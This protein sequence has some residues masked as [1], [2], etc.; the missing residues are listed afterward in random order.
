MYNESMCKS[1]IFEIYKIVYLHYFKWL[2]FFI[3]IIIKCQLF[4]GKVILFITNISLR[5]FL[6]F[7]ASELKLKSSSEVIYIDYS[8]HYGNRKKKH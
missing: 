5:S 8:K 3:K 4:S 1:K 6:L 7:S 2:K